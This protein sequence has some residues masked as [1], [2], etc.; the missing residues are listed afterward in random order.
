[1]KPAAFKYIAAATLNDAL[2]LKAKYGD[3]A[4]FLAGGQSLVPMLNFRVAQPSVV[5]DLNALSQLSGITQENGALRVGALTRYRTLERD[6]VVAEALPLVCEALPHIAHPQIRN[7]GTLGGNLAHAD[8]ASELPAIVLALDGRL[9]A[10]SASGERWIAARDFFVGPLTTALHADEMLVDI[11]LPAHTKRSGHCF[12]EVA[13]RRGDFAL[14]GIAVSLTLGVFGRCNHA[15]LALCGA[16]DTPIDVSAAAAGLIGH[17]VDAA[18]I[19]QVAA[20][21]QTAIDPRGNVHASKG[22]QRHLAGVLV[23]RALRTAT[24]RASRG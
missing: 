14:M 17:S 11:E 23:K 13:R 1:M 18:A 9:R 2:S 3:D 6:P 12:M 21:V 22:F 7:R 5:I 15:R 16:G 8:P 10:Q 4:R 19:D 20:S 24:E